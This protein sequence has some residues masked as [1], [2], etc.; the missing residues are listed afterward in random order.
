M[1]QFMRRVLLRCLHWASPVSGCAAV[2]PDTSLMFVGT[3][4][5]MLPVSGR[6]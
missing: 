5:Q 2:K 1:L 4:K 3:V 6:V